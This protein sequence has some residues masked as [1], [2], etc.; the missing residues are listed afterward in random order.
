MEALGLRRGWLLLLLLLWAA[1]AAALAASIP[2]CPKL[3]LRLRTRPTT[4]RPGDR[5]ALT[6]KIRN[7]RQTPLDGVAVRLNLPAGLVPSTTKVSSYPSSSSSQPIIIA[8]DTNGSV[9]AYWVNMSVKKTRKL[10]L[11]AH[12]C[13]T[14]SAGSD[15]LVD[16]YA[17][18][19]NISNAVTCLS[20]ATPTRVGTYVYTLRRSWGVRGM[21]NV[22]SPPNHKSLSSNALQVHV[23]PKGAWGSP[24]ARACPTLPPTPVGGDYSLYGPNQRLAA[25]VLVGYIGADGRRQLTGASGWDER[26]TACWRLCAGRN[27]AVPFYFSVETSGVGACYCS[28]EK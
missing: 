15:L 2:A 23:V 7:A 19:F 1:V 26:A 5:M 17:Y 22:C 12:V 24:K 28:Q 6:V 8:G 25:G 20:R 18:M 9:A 3:T 10:L 11:K 4:V 21:T 16:A 27:F 14:V 13:A